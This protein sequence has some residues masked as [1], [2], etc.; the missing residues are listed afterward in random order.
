MFCKLCNSRFFME[1]H[2]YLLA[3]AIILLSTKV[4]GLAT[5]LVNMPQIVGALLAGLFLGPAGFGIVKNTDLLDQLASLGVIFL[6]FHAGLETDIKE[7]KKMGVA[8]LCIAVL[9]VIL[10]LVVGTVV[11][12]AFFGMEDHIAML[13]A[14][15]TGV[16]LTATSVSITVEALR[17]MGKLNSSVGSVILGAAQI[18]DILGIII[19]TVVSGV[20]TPNTDV[21]SVFI[22]IGLYV[23]FLIVVSMVIKRFFEWM[24][25]KRA[26]SKR[27]AVFLISFCLLMTYVTETYFGVADITGA[28][29]A[30]M[31][32]CHIEKTRNT[33]SEK[34]D[35]ASYLFFSPVFFASIGL[36]TD[37]SD[38][39][40]HLVLFC[41]VL[42]IVAILSKM[43]GCGLGAKMMKFSNR[44]A[45][46]VGIG[47][48]SR[49]EVALI[50]ARKGQEANILDSSI[51][52]AIV[53]MVIVTTLLTPIMLGLAFGK[54]KNDKT[55]VLN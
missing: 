5:E 8:S 31:M 44:E 39:S 29:F 30:G 54:E 55:P 48:V 43:I 16:V 47:M 52:P 38:F 51:F 40:G 14:V 11:Y 3:L 10:P 17:E 28:Y 35:I 9:G 4:L 7:L 34:V 6:M 19:L 23:V 21:S 22:K 32:V 13:K 41:L 46:C 1:G 2:T 33:V 36:Q 50:V 24:N 26:Y 25:H 37:L 20:A 27:T 53:L 15:F 42:M 49:G 12:S 18:D 45:L